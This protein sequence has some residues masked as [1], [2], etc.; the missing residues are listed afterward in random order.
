MSLASLLDANAAAPA[1]AAHLDALTP[2]ARRADVLSL[3]R[4]H[5]AKLFEAV[6]GASA[7]SVDDMTLD[8]APLAGVPWEGVNS[9]PLFRSFAKVFYR[10]DD[11]AAAK[12]E[13]W[14]YNRT[15]GLVTTTVGP[16]Y[17]VAV[18]HGAKEVLVDYTRTPPKTPVGGPTFLPNDA[19][20]SRFV[21]YGTQDVLRRVSAHVAIGRAMR[22]GKWLDN[23]FVLCR[24]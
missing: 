17:Y 23:W 12:G 15:N 4:A 14:G 18:P 10:P 21:Y 20:L 19:R 1:L 9:L 3:S 6:D 11:A 24:E 22:D 7:I 13:R 8:A 5:Q 16:G 2:D